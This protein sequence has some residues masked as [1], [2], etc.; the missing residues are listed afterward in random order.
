MAI[1]NS[2]QKI[3]EAI[4]HNVRLILAI[5]WLV[6]IASMFYDPITPY[7]TQPGANTPFALKPEIYLNPERCVRVQGECMEEQTFSM[8]NMIFWAMIVP[9][10]ILILMTTG[11]EL[12]RRICPLS[13]LSQIPRSLGLVRQRKVIQSDGTIAYETVKVAQDSWLGKNHLYLQFGLFIVGLA[14]RI[15]FINGDRYAL[16]TFLILTI[17]SAILVGYLYDGKSWC[18]YFCPMAPVQ[19]IYVGP[20]AMWGTKAHTQTRPA[21][22]QSTC[23]TVDENGQEQSACVGCKVGCI[24]ID[25]E[26]SYW[27]ELEKP[28]RRLVQYGYLGMVI[29]FYLYFFLYSGDWKYYFTGAWSHEETIV[30]KL[31]D[32]GFYLYGQ[33]IP[34]PRAIAV[35]ITFGVLTLATYL[36]GLI[37]ERLVR[38]VVWRGVPLSRQ[39]AQHITFTLFTVISFYTFFSYGARPTI[40]RFPEWAVLGFNG[41]VVAAGAIWFMQTIGRTQ[42]QYNRETAA[43]TLRNQLRKIEVPQRIL[44]GR[45]IE[46]LSSDEIFT[47]VNAHREF[48]KQVRF[49]SY[50]SIVKDLL[51]DRT[52]SAMHSLEYCSG[53]RQDL[54]LSSEDH[55]RAIQTIAETDADLLHA[56]ASM[57]VPLKTRVLK[58]APASLTAKV[59][60]AKPKTAILPQRPKTHVIKRKDK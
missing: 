59:E 9:A 12:W 23:R 46:Q 35:F 51:A 14:I 37:V 3:P 40:N 17:L 27:Q 36:L 7:F 32:P 53:L 8:S 26:Q 28:G 42:H 48:S 54:G 60:N 29:A 13:F 19:M 39:Q 38:R 30:S 1:P 41:I 11:H 5:G 49:D 57:T 47:L 6:L 15:L 31:F 34:I 44:Q 18:Q 50:I 25:S 16:G 52:T 21:I 20:R 10:G 43:A 58:T 45:T 55:H 22:T 33:T 4:M 24:D 2:L 56:P